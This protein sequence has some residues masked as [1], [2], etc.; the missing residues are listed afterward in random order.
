MY[1]TEEQRIE[2][3][4]TL[5][6]ELLSARWWIFAKRR[7]HI[8]QCK[9]CQNFLLRKNNRKDYLCDFCFISGYGI[10]RFKREKVI[11]NSHPLVLDNAKG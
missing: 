6:K 5:T 11:H 1:E 4:K 3:L 2:L 7:K 10:A 8:V 9:K